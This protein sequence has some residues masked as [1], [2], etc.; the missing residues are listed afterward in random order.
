MPPS[1]SEL[2]IIVGL[3]REA[4]IVAGRGRVQVGTSGLAEALR[5]RP[6]GVM[7]FGLCGALDPALAVGD[8]VVGG[9]VAFARERYVADPDWADSLLGALPGARRGDVAG[10][11]AMVPTAR[12]KAAMRRATGAAIVDMETL[13]VARA[14][15]QAGLPFAVLRAVSDNAARDLPRA[16]QAGFKADGEPDVLAVI[17]ALARRPKELPDL[18]RVGREAETA[19]QRLKAAAGAAWPAPPS[20]ASPVLPA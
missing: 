11:L 17:A 12:A 15:T 9:L 7:S 6:A 3:K 13:E 10:S 16:A 1:P 5:A 4:K 2:L 14:A 18:I 8:L 20:P 19:F